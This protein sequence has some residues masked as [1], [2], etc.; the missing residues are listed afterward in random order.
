MTTSFTKPEMMSNTLKENFCKNNT[1]SDFKQSDWKKTA[2]AKMK[3]IPPAEQNSFQ[4]QAK[5]NAPGRFYTFLIFCSPKR[6]ILIPRA[7]HIENCCS[8]T[9]L[10]EK[11][12]VSFY[13][14]TL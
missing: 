10:V 8:S 12:V 1:G 13:N 9:P 7:F 4:L 2:T 11:K 6:S 3:S 14:Y 5:T